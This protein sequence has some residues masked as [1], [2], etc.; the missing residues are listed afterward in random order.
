MEE[1]TK[2]RLST[3][4]RAEEDPVEA[5]SALVSPGPSSG[6]GLSLCRVLPGA[7]LVTVFPGKSEE[8]SC[9]E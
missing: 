9:H 2:L 4:E 8:T 6:M 5:G 7:M 1:E 3:E